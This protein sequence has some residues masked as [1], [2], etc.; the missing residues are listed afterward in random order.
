LIDA[1]CFSHEHDLELGPL[2]VVVDE[3]G[4]FLI[5]GIFLDWDIDGDS[6]FQID[7]ILFQSFNF[8]FGIF[9]L[10]QKLK[11]C[12]VGF[13]NFLFQ[14]EDVIRRVFKFAAEGLLLLQK[15]LDL[16]FRS[17]MVVLDVLLLMNGLFMCK[18]L[19]SHVQL[20]TL[21][22]IDILSMS[23]KLLSCRLSMILK[24]IL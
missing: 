20:E 11:R 22:H 19:G 21:K 2:R 16:L 10:F 1:F 15:L 18:N 24:V 8:N 12:L 17:G 9:Q 14:F 23:I 5:R 6:L 7:D 3:L 4:E 13:V